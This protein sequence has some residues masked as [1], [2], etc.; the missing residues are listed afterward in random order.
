MRIVY[1]SSE[2][3]SPILKFILSAV[4][5]LLLCG[6]CLPSFGSIGHFAFQI[7]TAAV[8]SLICT[9]VFF[10]LFKGS[11]KIIADGSTVFLLVM[12]LIAIYEQIKAQMAMEKPFSEGWL[13]T[14]YYDKPL[15]VAVVWGTVFLIVLVLRL[16]LPYTDNYSEFRSDFT[17]FLRRASKGFIIF[18][19][20]VLLYC[21]VLQRSPQTQSGVNLIPF[22]MIMTYISSSTS[23]YERL[24]YF[25][26]NFLCFFPFGFLFK[27]FK[28]DRDILKTV[29]LPIVLS[30]LIEVSQFLLKNGNL[31][32][33]DV[34]LNSLGF[35]V[36]YFICIAFDKIRQLITK[37]EEKSIFN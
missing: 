26:G 22:N 27:V 34:L 24:F 23:L 30:L 33:D 9:A 6:C 36:G 32:V 28:K 11:L 15:T 35:Y 29:L 16:V 19:A 25:T 18:Y 31:D 4:F 1:K 8:L 7:S 3:A 13:Y 5:A 21:F 12:L 17:L 14:F 37:S 2:D 20:F 10:I